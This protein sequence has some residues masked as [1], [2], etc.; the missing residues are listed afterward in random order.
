MI[1]CINCGH[2]LPDRASF[3]PAC[4]ENQSPSDLSKNVPQSSAQEE[5][6]YVKELNTSLTSSA[7]STGTIGK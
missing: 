2:E 4:G 6:S 1:F 7:E 5:P 3:C